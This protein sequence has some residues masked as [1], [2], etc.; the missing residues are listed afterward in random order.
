MFPDRAR[1]S[2]R[3]WPA[4]SVLAVSLGLWAATLIAGFAHGPLTGV[5]AFDVVDVVTY[6]AL[7]TWAMTGAL[8]VG[9]RPGNRIGWLLSSS[10]LLTLLGTAATQYAVATLLDGWTALPG[11]RVAAWLAPWTTVL[12]LSLWFWLLL[13]FPDGHLPGPRWRGVAWLYALLGVAGIGSLALLPTTQPGGFNELG[14]IPNP[15]EWEA[16]VEVLRPVNAVAQVVATVLIG[17][18]AASMVMRLR[19]ATGVQ[20]QQ[21]KWLAYAAV[22]LAGLYLTT[23]LYTR[24]T[25][26]SIPVLIDTAINGLG[27]V[28]APAA[29]G[30]AILRYQLYDID[31]LINRTLVYGL[32]TILLG[33]GYAVSV[34]VFGQIA[35]RDRSSLAVAAATLTVAVLF[36]PARRSLQDAV[37]R[38]F[39]RRRY[40]TAR[41]IEGFS[42][43]LRDELDLDAL[44]AELRAVVDRTMEP[45]SVSLDLY[46]QRLTL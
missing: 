37:D 22:L 21:L 31:R 7:L 38:R 1:A 44:S 20:R 25:I 36:Q 24:G 12:G 33:L 29:I 23:Y 19:R 9:R 11:G 2:G 28:A 43:R 39:N 45:T 4:W 17:A 16:A 3:T 27:L 42:T 14:P 5:P 13:L 35:G 8:I 41:A 26:G 15:L 18:A 32:L 6:T 34:L 46:N 10:A 40:D 30:T